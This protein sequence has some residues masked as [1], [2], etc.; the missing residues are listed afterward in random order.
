MFA[1]QNIPRTHWSSPEVH[2]QLWNVP[3]TTAKLELTLTMQRHATGASALLEYDADRFEA[4]S[5]ERML[6]QLRRLLEAVVE[7]PDRRLSELPLLSAPERAATIATWTARRRG[8][9][10]LPIHRVFEQQARRSPDAIAIS[11]EAG[12]FTYRDVEERANQLAH[13]LI[14]LDLG[15][16]PLV[17]VCIDRSPAFVIAALAILESGGAYVPVDRLAP[18]ARRTQM[19]D[20]VTAIVCDSSW[21]PAERHVPVV[22]IHDPAIRRR[23][24]ICPDLPSSPEQLAYVMFTSGSTGAPRGVCVPH[25]GVTRL[26]VGTDYARFGPDEIFLQ[27]APVAF[28]ASTFEIWGALLNG[29]TLVIAPPRPHSIAELG[30]LIARHRITTVWLTSGLFELVVDTGVDALAGVRQVLTGGDVMSASHAKRFLARMPDCRLINGYGPTENTTF[31]STH[32]VEHVDGA[33][34]PIGRPIAGTRVY[35]LDA[36]R[37]PVPP[38]VIGEAYVAGAGLARGY[39]DEPDATRERFVSD[40]FV[41][42]DVMYRTGD[43][44]R[45]RND[46]ALDFVGRNDRQVKIRGYRVEPAEI[47]AQLHAS[48]DVARAVVI[49]VDDERLVAFVVPRDRDEGVASRVAQHLRARLPSYLQPSRIAVVSQLPLTT[50]G[51]IDRR[52]LAA[53]AEPAPV[54][55]TSTMDAYEQQVARLYEQVL[56]VQV[57]GATDNFFEL[58]GDSFSA[59][60]LAA[61]IEARL[62]YEMPLASLFEKPTIATLA[63]EL[64]D[65]TRAPADLGRH[66]VCIKDGTRA[67]ALFLVAGG[68][69]GR[70]ELAICA[71]L[72]ARLDPGERV[73]GVLPPRGGATLEAIAAGCV[74]EVQRIQPK[75]PYRL[76][77]ECTGGLVAYEMAQQLC[78]AGERVELL[79]LIDTWCPSDKGVLY[80]NWIG[81]P[82]ALIRAGLAFLASLPRRPRGAE[83]WPV[84]LWRRAVVPAA[85]RRHVRA[86]MRYR[87]RPFS[88]P[89]TLLACEDNIRRGLVAGWAQVASSGIEVH[90]APGDHDSYS[91]EHVERTAEVLRNCLAH[92]LSRSRTMPAVL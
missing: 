60:E 52:A 47:E 36:R 77:G 6:C 54:H 55:S 85:E 65:R 3:P 79:L 25:R 70:A 61:A 72:A 7:D 91:R 21:Q 64:R 40:P 58:G 18:A 37:E 17:G 62:G 48:P 80:H 10:V 38:G 75:G 35:V 32:L 16:E 29:A 50:N 53:A 19:L 20:R 33:S 83:A 39:L 31:T 8:D 30:R 67:T 59:I 66:L 89:L 1:S 2:A 73:F 12:T 81:Q 5:I 68:R 63:E 42:R 46:G 4:V 86:C 41:S 84:E 28:D 71:K 43:L 24:V 76:G 82:R 27:L 69:G 45:M 74:R 51:K 11:S 44:V 14:A 92:E 34:V 90:R 22:D 9:D 57:A 13:H 88:I 49:D 26:V 56:G 23:P 87:P 15:P 78:A